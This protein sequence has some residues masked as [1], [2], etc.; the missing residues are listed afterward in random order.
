[1]FSG[2]GLNG[3]SDSFFS[4]TELVQEDRDPARKAGKASAAI[5]SLPRRRLFVIRERIRS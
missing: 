1:M 3:L 2:R 4:V 5:S